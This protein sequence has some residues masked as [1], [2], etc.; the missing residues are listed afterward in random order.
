MGHRLRTNF[1]LTQSL[2]LDRVG[3]C[4]LQ[5]AV[6]YNSPLQ[7]CPACKQYVE[8]DQT[9]DECIARNG[10]RAETCPLLENLSIPAARTEATSAAPPD[11][12]K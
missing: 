6:M 8:L 9:R 4:H 10:C 11:K 3:Q 2:R 5:E 12:G 7:F 1:D